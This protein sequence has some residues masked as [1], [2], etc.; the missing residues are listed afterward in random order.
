MVAG[1]VV[2]YIYLGN[3]T[4]NPIPSGQP[5]GTSGS[6]V[7][8][9]NVDG[10]STTAGSKA[11]LFNPGATGTAPKQ[12]V[13]GT[14]GVTF[15]TYPGAG[16]NASSSVFLDG[17]FQNVGTIGGNAY[18]AVET[19]NVSGPDEG[20]GNIGT[21]P[22][23]ENGV[24]LLIEGG[25]TNAVAAF[26]GVGNVVN[27]DPFLFAPVVS[28]YEGSDQDAGSWQIASDDAFT[29]TVPTTATGGTVVVDGQTFTTSPGD[30]V[31]GSTQDASS[32]YN[33]NVPEPATLTLLGLGLSSLLLRRRQK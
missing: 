1:N 21:G 7:V 25:N 26:G 11:A 31:I 19:I 12:W 22:G 2:D 6:W 10:G 20:I 4:R 29:Y 23:L 32:L 5:A 24:N 28:Q 33:S 15:N 8:Y 18:C 3:S 17:V 27:F 16:S 13:E 30:Q 14:S 9:D